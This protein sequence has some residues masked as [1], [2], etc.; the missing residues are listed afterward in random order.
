VI[1]TGGE[2]VSSL[3]VESVI[4]GHPAVER[5]VVIGLPHPLWGEAVT[6]L[7]RPIA[8]CSVGE[9]ELLEY[10]RGSLAGFEIPKAVLF[11]DEFPETVGDKVKKH[12]LRLRYADLYTEAG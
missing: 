12:E 1:K 9:R 8:G 7:V 3:R 4:S 11:V 6:V 5:A 10:A 2:N